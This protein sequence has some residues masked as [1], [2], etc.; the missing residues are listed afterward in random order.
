M[1]Q[2]AAVA[3]EQPMG[4]CASLERV[5]LEHQGR[6]FRAAYRVTGNAQDAEDVLQTV[7]LRLARQ[8]ESIP[9]N[10]PASYLYRAAVNSALDLLRSRRD[11]HTVPIEEAAS[12]P[13][14][15]SPAPDRDHE[16]AE[17][18]R[19]LRQAVAMLPPR[20]AEMFALRYFEG[21]ANRDIA[22][23]LGVTRITVAVTLHRARKSLQDDLRI[24]RG[25]R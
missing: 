7:F 18:R 22:R 16:A 23:M 4:D 25:T 12:A 11:K 1:V 21:E 24:L 10:N 6:V 19:R 17:V 8:G 2:G 13:D 3:V 20:A 9:M 15:S 5:F 14:A